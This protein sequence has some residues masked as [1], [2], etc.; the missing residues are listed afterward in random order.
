MH[1]STH[2][3]KLI[4]PY[5]EHYKVMYAPNIYVNTHTNVQECAC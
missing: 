3:V 2:M 1:A 4:I 5:K